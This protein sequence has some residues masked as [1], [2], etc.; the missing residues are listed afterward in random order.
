MYEIKAADLA[1]DSPNFGVVRRTVTM[2]G[3]GPSVAHLR[4]DGILDK[5]GQ[6]PVGGDSLCFQ[7]SECGSGT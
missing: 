2:T 7:A 3:D 1:T 4:L 5:T 6:V